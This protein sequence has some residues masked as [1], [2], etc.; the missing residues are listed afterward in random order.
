MQ[1]SLYSTAVQAGQD[2]FK[3]CRL[4]HAK[5]LSITPKVLFSGRG[6]IYRDSIQFY[7]LFCLAPSLP[8][9]TQYVPTLSLKTLLLWEFISI[10]YC[11]GE[12]QD[13]GD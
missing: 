8:L 4:K 3:T 7:P 9:L 6:R 11:Q 1:S 12:K 5:N 13:F 2:T 10:F